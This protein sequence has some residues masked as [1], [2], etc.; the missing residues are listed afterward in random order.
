SAIPFEGHIGRCFPAIQHFTYDFSPGASKSH[1]SHAFHASGCGKTH[2]SWPHKLT[3]V[4]QIVIEPRVSDRLCRAIDDDY[5]VL[6]VGVG[7]TMDLRNQPRTA[8]LIENHV[9]VRP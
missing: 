9:P 4:C 5:W 1:A 6:N 8:V 2:K 3:E 7:I